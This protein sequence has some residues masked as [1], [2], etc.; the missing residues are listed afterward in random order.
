MTE[1][2]TVSSIKRLLGCSQFQKKEASYALERGSIIHSILENPAGYDRTGS[3]YRGEK[4]PY[5]LEHD[6]DEYEQIVENTMKTYP[7][8]FRGE[9]IP[10]TE[11]NLFFKDEILGD[12]ELSGI[13]DKLRLTPDKATIIDWKTG[14]TRADIN[15][16]L[17]MLQALFYTFLIMYTYQNIPLVEFNYVYVEQ[18]YKISLTTTNDYEHRARI[19]RSLKMWLF[20]TKYAGGN[21]RIG[22]GCAHCGRLTSCPYVNQE[23]TLLE[24]DPERL[25]VKKIK[26]LKSLITHIYDT[27]KNEL[28]DELPVDRVKLMNYYY[29]KKSELTFEKIFE[30]TPDTIKITKSIADSLMGSQIPI[31]NKQTK[32]LK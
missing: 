10:E 23:L 3:I 26:L 29:V 22:A 16:P 15:N 9:W 14:V 31:I 21:L 11:L 20:A 24:V 17:D 8:Y 32:T 6:F 2:Y 27:R 7:E 4:R 18:D 1:K 25:D 12:I 5:N 13:L 30:L 28:I 19:Y